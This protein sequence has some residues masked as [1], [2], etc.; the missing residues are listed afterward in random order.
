[1]L[2]N[3][4]LLIVSLFVCNII[5]SQVVIKGHI[6]EFDGGALI[7]ATVVEKGTNNG[8][9]ADV[10]GNFTITLNTTP[11]T[12]VFSYVGFTPQEIEVTA[13]TTLR[14]ILEADSYSLSQ[15]E[16]LGTR[17]LNRSSTES[18]V[19]IDIIDV[20]AV[21]AANGQLDL[22]QLLQYAAPSFNSNRQ[23]GSDGADHIDPATLRGL[24]PDQTLVLVNG[25]RYHQSSLINIFGTRGRG[26]TGTDLNTIPAAAIDRI[27]ILRDGASAQYGSDAIAGVIN[28][29][30][31]DD[32]NEFTGN[33]NTSGNL[34]QYNFDQGSIDGQ[35]LQIN[36]NYGFDIG[37]KGFMNV[38]AD[39]HYRGHT[40]RAEFT[41]DFP[42]NVDVRNQYGDAE[43]TD[44]SAWF[45]MKYQLSDNAHFYAFGG[46]NTRDVA[47]YAY[48]RDAG[49]PRTVTSI[50]PKGFDPII[51]SIVTDKSISGGIR[52]DIHGWDVDFNNTFGA[53]KMHYY[54]RETLNA[55]MGDASPTEFDDGGFSLAQNTTSLDFTKYFSSVLKGLNI[56]YGAEY[57]IDNYQIFAGEEASWYNYGAVLIDGEDTIGRPGG[58]Q[59]F[60][61]FQPKDVTNEFR[62]NLGAYFDVEANFTEQFSADAAIRYENYSDFGNTINGKLAARFAINNKFALRGS[63]STGFRAPSLAQIYFSST[64]TNVEGG[65]IIDEVI[66]DNKSTIARQLGIP[67][68]KQEESMNGSFGFTAKPISGLSLTI[69]GYYI[70]INDRI[71]LT[72]GFGTDDDIIGGILSDLNVGYARFFTNAVDTKTMGVDVI[73]AYKIYMQENVLTFTYAGNFNQ[74][75]IENIY[76]NELLTGKEENY[77]SV[78]EQYFL[79]ASAPPAK[80]NL[81][82]EYST[83]KLNATLRFNYFGEINLINY[84]GLEYTYAAKTTIDA[85]IGYD[86]TKNSHLTIGAAN[87]LNTYPD[88]TDPYETETGGAWDAVQMGYNGTAIFA[89]LGFK[90]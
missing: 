41:G 4:Y 46:Y 24:G 75:T 88:P 16:V 78:R 65:V 25:K 20:S 59:G 34:A 90:F 64:Y 1:M 2:K 33:V 79:L 55:S 61:G 32:V 83:K 40:N 18:M 29:V 44:F 86:I 28:I 23:S 54:G 13:Q 43:V 80:M 84:S 19:P 39:Y 47:A 62:S 51:A 89:K 56:A 66:A 42:D 63:F 3:L 9:L 31:K 14:I 45:N 26:N 17:S 10:D 35:N 85:S 57:R 69:D 60:P 30:L 70:A 73:L 50:Y 52:G 5:N 15:V 48:T 72:D 71:V 37:E 22:N 58:S 74:M 67:A 53:N 8:T 6:S 81:T 11:A 68:L 36:G 82:T 38:T 49:S 76:T 21:T 12:L 7:G 77:F 87:L 27:E